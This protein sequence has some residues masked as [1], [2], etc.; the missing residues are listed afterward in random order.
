VTLRYVFVGEG[1]A[2]PTYGLVV[3]RGLLLPDPVKFIFGV[4][5]TDQQLSVLNSPGVSAA[6]TFPGHGL[7]DYSEALEQLRLSS[8][9][10]HSQLLDGRIRFDLAVVVASPP[11]ASGQRHLGTIN[12]VMQAVVDAAERLVIEEDPSLPLVQ[13]SAVVSEAKVVDVI[14]HVPAPYVSLSRLADEQDHNIAANVAQLIPDGAV[15]QIGVGGIMDALGSAL[16]STQRLRL[17]TGAISEPVRVLVDK[18]C[19]DTAHTIDG[20][21]IVGT[22]DFAAWAASRSDLRLGSSGV[23]HNPTALASHRNFFSVNAAIS[24]DLNGNVNS[25]LVGTRRVAGLGGAPN[26]AEGA[27]ASIG[28]AAIVAVR[29][30]PSGNSINPELTDPTIPAESVDFIVSDRGYVD[31]SAVTGDRRHD[32]ILRLLR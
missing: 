13:G 7:R 23:I 4:R 1:T 28:G 30:H 15:L 10:L 26:F 27:H 14:P 3:A 2:E 17:I 9:D 20:G 18:G 24:V 11:D 5:R 12:G 21:S 31:L 22:S 16:S 25:E 29:R 32:E 8:W 19:L 6:G